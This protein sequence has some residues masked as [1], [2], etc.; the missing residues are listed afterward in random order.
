MMYKE[1]SSVFEY[2]IDSVLRRVDDNYNKLKKLD[3]NGREHDIDKLIDDAMKRSAFMKAI[4]KV[5]GDFARARYTELF[6]AEMFPLNKLVC[7]DCGYYS[8]QIEDWIPYIRND[9]I[10]ESD[11]KDLKGNCPAC[12][13]EMD[14][15]EISICRMAWRLK[16][17]LKK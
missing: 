8:Y 17:V 9:K 2:F 14:V 5:S 3:K 4:K 10:M 12:G 6:H 1:I 7:P 11:E 16:Q 15:E 13:K